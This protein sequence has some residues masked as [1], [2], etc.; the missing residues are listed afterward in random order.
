MAVFNDINFVDSSSVTWST[1]AVP[2]G[3]S[4]TATATGGLLVASGTLTNAQ[5]KALHGTPISVIP[6]PG[7]GKA[8]SIITASA[9]MNYGGTNQF[10]AVASQTIALYYGTLIIGVAA[11]ISNTTLTAASTG[12]QIITSSS[13]NTT[14]YTNVSNVAVNAYNPIVTEIGGNA[15]AD[16][17]VSYNILYRIITIP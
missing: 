6:A 17:T 10:L 14:T 15:A 5:I 1:A 9:T 3:G 13:V 12:I 11:V 7:V 4:V 8:I 16:N 2:L